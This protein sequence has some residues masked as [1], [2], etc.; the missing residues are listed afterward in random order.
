VTPLEIQIKT[1]A[2]LQGLKLTEQGLQRV[3][4]ATQ[5][6]ASKSEAYVQSHSKVT[7]EMK[8]QAQAASEVLSDQDKLA[9]HYQVSAQAADNLGKNIGTLKGGFSGLSQ[10]MG[11]LLSGNITQVTQGFLTLS[12]TAANA[13]P[14][15]Q[16]LF[17]QIASGAAAAMVVAAPLIVAIGAM[18]QMAADN[19]KAMQ[20]WWG[21]AA[22][23]AEAY[24]QKSAEVKAAAQADLDAMLV[25]VRELAAGY[26]S[27]I[28]D[29]DRAQSRAKEVANAQKELA[30]AKATTPEEKAA[31]EAKFGAAGLESDQ[32][33]AGV[34]QRNAEETLTKARGQMDDAEAGVRDAEIAFQNNPT[35]ANQDAVKAA[36]A[37]RDKVSSEISPVIEKSYSEMEAARHTTKIAGIR[38]DTLKVQSSRPA[39]LPSIRPEAVARPDIGAPLDRDR[40]S[41]LRQTAEVAQAAGDWSG[42]AAAVDEL[43]KMNAAAKAFASAVAA[44]A[45]G[46]TAALRKTESKLKRTQQAGPGGGG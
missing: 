11:G 29:M 39:A 33:N 36:K 13:S 27:L 3:K 24:K 28:S 23:S 26:Q 34:R 7:D 45:S 10:V 2:D 19:E 43:R 9:K 14:A 35:R 44:N 16:A 37:N 42:Q 31:I 15:I 5:Q 18:K 32:L 21:E 1:T 6:V 20:R 38:Q 46:T 8:R 25:K 22:K 30:L 40:A 41:A 17:G 4:E 12:K